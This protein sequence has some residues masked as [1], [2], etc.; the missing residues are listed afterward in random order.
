MEGS[1]DKSPL[2]EPTNATL[3]LKGLISAW[4]SGEN[5]LCSR[6]R[7]L[8]LHHD[9][10]QQ[11]QPKIGLINH[12]GRHANYSLDVKTHPNLFSGHADCDPGRST[13]CSPRHDVRRNLPNEKTTFHR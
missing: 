2:W 1:I 5:T 4:L 6:R 10:T 11:S 12:Y 8:G 9:E 7:P 13:L 3:V